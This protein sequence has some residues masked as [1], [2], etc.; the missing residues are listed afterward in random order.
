MQTS[1]R[2]CAAER[3]VLHLSAA[4]YG[5]E[6]E[7]IAADRHRS[8]SLLSARCFWSEV[9]GTFWWLCPS[10]GTWN[11]SVPGHVYLRSPACGQPWGC[12]RWSST[13]GSDN[14]A[15]GDGQWQDGC[16]GSV[17][18]A[19][20]CARNVP[21]SI[22]TNRQTLSTSRSRAFAPLAEQRWIT[23]TLA[24]LREM[25]VITAKRQEFLPGQRPSGASSDPAPA[26]KKTP[27]P[28]N[29]ARG[30]GRNAAMSSQV[31]EEEQ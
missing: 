8:S 5:Q 19:G 31:E 29:R 16:G 17:E 10:T 15:D 2:A 20:G 7:P 23:T 26:P 25:D 30:R 27:K 4:I 22:F 18:L 14:R 9:S 11:A 13:F 3:H 12:S 24:Y 28:N 1:G 21:S 6:D